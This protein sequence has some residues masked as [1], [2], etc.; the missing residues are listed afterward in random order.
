MLKLFLK[1]R[2]VPSV[3]NCSGS[4]CCGG[5]GLIPGP[6]QWVKGSGVAT[7][8]VPVTAAAQIRT[9]P[10]NFHILQVQP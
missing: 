10:W 4:G 1:R 5:A 6:A 8:A 3:V 7:A 9:W 2:G